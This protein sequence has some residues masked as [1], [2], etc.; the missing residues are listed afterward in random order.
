MPTMGIHAT[1]QNR[2]LLCQS[3]GGTRAREVHAHES[4]N[5]VERLYPV[6]C[7]YASPRG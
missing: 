4:M 1:Y 6:T 3:S 5:V 7:T 2:L